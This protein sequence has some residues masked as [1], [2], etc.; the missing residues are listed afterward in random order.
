[1]NVETLGWNYISKKM[2]HIRLIGLEFFSKLSNFSYSFIYFFIIFTE[3]SP[4]LLYIFSIYPICSFIYLLSFFLSFFLISQYLFS[5]TFPFYFFRI[6][7][8]PLSALHTDLFIY[9]LFLSL[10]YSSAFTAFSINTS[11]YLI[12]F[13]IC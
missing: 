2:Y 12:R 5:V 3:F 6:C 8:L 13:Y 11:F 10:L 1:M 4:S 7:S 9:Y